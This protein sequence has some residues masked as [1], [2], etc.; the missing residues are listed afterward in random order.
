MGEKVLRI[1]ITGAN[2]FLGTALVRKLTGF[3]NIEVVALVRNKDSLSLTE[4]NVRII[5]V[6]NYFKFT[7]WGNGKDD[8]ASK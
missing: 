5:E 1:L 6:P 2:G 8:Y 7:K 3:S 4:E